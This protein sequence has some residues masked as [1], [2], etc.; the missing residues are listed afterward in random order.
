MLSA[1]L[2]G[3]VFSAPPIIKNY[4]IPSEGHVHTVGINAYNDPNYTS[5]C[6]LIDWGWLDPGDQATRTIY[7][8][9]DGNVPVTLSCVT[10]DWLPVEAP[11]YL[12]FSWDKEGALLD[13][14]HGVPCVLTLIVDQDIQ[15]TTISDFSFNI[16]LTGTQT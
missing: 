7:L 6:I 4:T 9:N 11:S 5:P 13:G 3:I 10:I 14:A 1:G 12:S 15:N 8:Y 2:L 16:Q